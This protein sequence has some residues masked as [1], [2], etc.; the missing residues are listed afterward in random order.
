[1]I[2]VGDLVIRGESDAPCEQTISIVTSVN[3]EHAYVQYVAR[4]LRKHTS[5]ELRK[6][7]PWNV[8]DLVKIEEFGV[9]WVIDSNFDNEPYIRVTQHNKGTATYK[10]GR[11][12][13]WQPSGYACVLTD[14]MFGLVK[15]L[16]G[17]YK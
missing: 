12:R 3:G 10:D 16:T 14:T 17:I 2:K 6:V 13:R 15:R 9:S 4:R 7:N 5:A 1:M 11:P 8:A